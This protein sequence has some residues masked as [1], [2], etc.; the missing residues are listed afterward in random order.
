[1][2]SNFFKGIVFGSNFGF[3]VHY[4]CLK[5]FTIIKLQYVAQIQI[6]KLKFQKGLQIILLL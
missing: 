5:K 3:K 6:K 2:Y 4:K 1:M